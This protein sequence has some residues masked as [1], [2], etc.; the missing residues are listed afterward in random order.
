[1]RSSALGAAAEHGVPLLVTTFCAERRP[2]AIQADQEIVQRRRELLRSL[3]FAR[4]NI[5][6]G[7][8][9]RP[10][11]TAR[12]GGPIR[13][14]PRLPPARP[15][16]LA[17]SSIVR[18]CRANIV[19]HFRWA[20]CPGRCGQDMKSSCPNCIPDER[21]RPSW[22]YECGRW[23]AGQH[24]TRRKSVPAD[25]YRGSND[26]AGSTL[27][28]QNA[29]MPAAAARRADRRG[30]SRLCASPICLTSTSVGKTDS[31][32]VFEDKNGPSAPILTDS[33]GRHRRD[34]AGRRRLSSCA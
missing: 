30:T 1:V 25:D 15:D 16:C 21:I 13:S 9:S 8:Q 14:H 2:G 24:A 20:C 19:D 28:R 31:D 5:A 6:Q 22:V 26:I 10:G 11:G 18:L 32:V 34:I 23:D 7:Q 4:R 29:I 27:G 3:L 33:S 12:S 17:G